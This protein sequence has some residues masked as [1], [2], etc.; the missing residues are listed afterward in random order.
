[1]VR[2]L[3]AVLLLLWGL[4][5]CKGL[6]VAE[7]SEQEKIDLFMTKQTLLL[8]GDEAR[9]FV[10]VGSRGLDIFDL[11]APQK[12]KLL[13]NYA[14]KA[15]T[16]A[17]ARSA[18]TLFLAN[19]S[20][21]VEILDI[22]DAEFPRSI[23][24]IFAEDLNATSIALSADEKT[25]AVGTTEGVNLYDV[26]HRLLPA[27]LGSYESN[28]TIMDLH[29]GDADRR[30]YLA[31]LAYG[32][33]VVDISVPS[34]PQ[35]LGSVML[36]G[37]SCDIATA[38]SRNDLYMATLTSA[39]KKI[40]FDDPE[41]PQYSIFYD[42]HDAGTIWDIAIDTTEYWFYLARGARGMEIVKTETDGTATHIAAFDTNGMA[43]GI[44]VNRAGTIAYIADGEEGLKVIDISDKNAPVRTGYA[45]F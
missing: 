21:G 8:S 26:T 15:K 43:R 44:T 1:M 17:L 18:D 14:T 35:L 6:E 39:L 27:Y 2:N 13:K 45:A 33:E 38:H 25:V 22:S 16:Y 41:A 36:E 20:E 30:L 34:R 4:G 28:G 19:G 32:F 29:F 37:G 11:T 7:E 40:R 24:A 3:I 9:L 31:N 10:S 5:G 42:A 12:P 23:A